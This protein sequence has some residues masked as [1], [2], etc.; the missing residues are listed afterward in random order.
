MFELKQYR[1]VVFN[2]IKELCKIWTKTDVW[3]EK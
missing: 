1:G 2:D 3:F